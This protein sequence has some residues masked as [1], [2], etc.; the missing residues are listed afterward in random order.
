M[1][2]CVCACELPA[3]GYVCFMRGHYQ[4]FINSLFSG[5]PAYFAIPALAQTV[6]TQCAVINLRPFVTIAPTRNCGSKIGW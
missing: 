6:W 4:V 2:V 5:L 1:C 3:C